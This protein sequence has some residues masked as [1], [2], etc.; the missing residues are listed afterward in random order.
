MFER[1]HMKAIASIIGS[2]EYDITKDVFGNSITVREHLIEGFINLFEKD[3]PRFNSE[4]FVEA[5]AEAEGREVTGFDCPY[6]GKEY[7]H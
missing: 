5:V 6:C 7:G 4:R 3:N 2:L 1:R